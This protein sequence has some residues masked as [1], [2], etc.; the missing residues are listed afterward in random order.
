M[1]A[2]PAAT[3]RLGMLILDRYNMF[4]GEFCFGDYLVFGHP[5]FIFSFPVNESV[6][7]SIAI[8][9]NIFTF[10]IH[11]RTYTPSNFQD[12]TRAKFK[13]KPVIS[14]YLWT[15]YL[16]LKLFAVKKTKD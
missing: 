12:H 13:W 4:L 15:I 6:V 7:G 8:F 16:C 3:S 5:F 11:S 14:L 9:A 1:L 10:L 2:R